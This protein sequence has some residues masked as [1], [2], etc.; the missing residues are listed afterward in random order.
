MQ[1]SFGMQGCD[2]QMSLTHSHKYA[3]MPFITVALMRTHG[4]TGCKKRLRGLH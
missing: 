2:L 1:N 4:I 3:C